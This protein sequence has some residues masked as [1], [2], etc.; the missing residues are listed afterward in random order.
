MDF[1]ED[2]MAWRTHD[3]DRGRFTPEQKKYFQT[4]A[5]WLCTRCEDVGA[6][7]G[8]SLAHLAQDEKKVLH[9]IHANHS[10]HKSAKRQPS[11]AFHGLRLVINL[12]RG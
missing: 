6:E 12:V 1:H 7:N 3:L 5:V 2:Y 9:R 8:K 4:E 10:S 11:A